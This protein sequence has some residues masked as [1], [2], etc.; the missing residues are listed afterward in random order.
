MTGADLERA[1]REA[2][3]KARRAGRSLNH[4]DLEKLL[5][6]ARPARSPSMRRRIAVHESGHALARIAWNFGIVTL[7]TIEDRDGMGFVESHRDHETIDTQE[8]CFALL[9]VL[10]A[11]HAAETV[12]YG[13]ALSGSGGSERSDL[14]RATHLAYLTEASIGF[15]STTPLLYR[16]AADMHAALRFDPELAARVNARLEAAHAAACGLVSRNQEALQH[17]AEALVRHGTLE[18]AELAAVLAEVRSQI[19]RPEPPLHTS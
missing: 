18:G 16:D 17:L 15:G 2:R 8:Q 6:G 12:I 19:E 7:I 5:A 9:Q 13:A 14:A 3:Q 10:L 1:V 4:S 11:G